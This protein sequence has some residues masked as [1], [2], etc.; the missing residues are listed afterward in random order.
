MDEVHKMKSIDFLHLMRNNNCL[1]V[2]EEY[3]DV[4]KQLYALSITL[5]DSTDNPFGLD[6]SFG[7]CAIIEGDECVYKAYDEETIENN[8]FDML[9]DVM[10]R[11]CKNYLIRILSVIPE[12]E[13]FGCGWK[14]PFYR[15]GFTLI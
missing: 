2:I 3:S 13:S 4:G 1:G 15:A 6:T 7:F 5:R 8:P 12:S 14:R 11:E 9:W 10:M